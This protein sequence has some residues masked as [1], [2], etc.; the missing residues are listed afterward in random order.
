MAPTATVK[1]VILSALLEGRW[2]ETVYALDD[3]N[4]K[5]ALKIFR[6]LNTKVRMIYK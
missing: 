1:H 6:E 5:E 2:I 4:W 3:P